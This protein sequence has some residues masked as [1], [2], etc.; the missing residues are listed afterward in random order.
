MAASDSASDT[1]RVRIMRPPPRGPEPPGRAGRSLP[2]TRRAGA[3]ARP[4]PAAPAAGGAPDT[5]RLVDSAR[6]GTFRS[7]PTLDAAPAPARRDHPGRM[8]TARRGRP[9]RA[10]PGQ[11]A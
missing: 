5:V 10:D 2:V 1:A 7:L 9:A 3:A 4:W 11:G 8:A 6:H